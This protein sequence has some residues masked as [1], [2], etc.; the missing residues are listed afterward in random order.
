[1]F[2]VSD[3]DAILDVML[4]RSSVVRDR[5]DGTGDPQMVLMRDWVQ[6][7]VVAAFALCTGT[8]RHI[9]VGHTA[10]VMAE[11]DP[12]RLRAA[13]VQTA[14]VCVAWAEA[15]DRRQPK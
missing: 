2:P 3:T 8:W 1:M 6:Q 7:D 9:L 13:L 14:A 15:I 5:A 11:S 12:G 10:D 4:E